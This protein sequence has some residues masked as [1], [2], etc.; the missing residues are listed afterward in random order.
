MI[1]FNGQKFCNGFRLKCSR[2]FR[3]KLIFQILQVLRILFNLIIF[4]RM[5]YSIKIQIVFNLMILINNIW[6]ILLVINYLWMKFQKNNK[7]NLRW[8]NIRLIREIIDRILKYQYKEVFY[9]IY[10]FPQ[11][12]WKYLHTIFIGKFY[13][14][15][16][17]F[18]KNYQ[19]GLS[20]GIEWLK[21]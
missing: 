15:S 20:L 8:L 16:I 6:L 14:I 9:S 10:Y 17:Q 5:P 13:I 12:N 4:K 2:N 7:Y 19:N 1:N 11:I 18:F 21:K 3:G